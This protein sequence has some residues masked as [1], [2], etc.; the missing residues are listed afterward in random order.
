MLLTEIMANIEAE[1]MI[2]K[3]RRVS[4]TDYAFTLDDYGK[5]SFI[6]II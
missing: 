5:M 6:K 4:A 3:K 1:A 2:N